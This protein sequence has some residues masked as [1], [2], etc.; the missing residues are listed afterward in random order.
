MIDVLVPSC[1]YDQVFC[2]NIRQAGPG[3][4]H[5]AL[6]ASRHCFKRKMLLEQ[7]F[8]TSGTYLALKVWQVETAPSLDD[9]SVT[10]YHSLLG[11]FVRLVVV[12]KL[13]NPRRW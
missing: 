13:P 2:P 11:T 8:K 1:G 12:A 10:I 4:H 6:C 9:E 5:E 7:G 3:E